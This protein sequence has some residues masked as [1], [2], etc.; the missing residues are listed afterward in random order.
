VLVGGKNLAM[1]CKAVL[2]YKILQYGQK[3]WAG[4]ELRLSRVPQDAPEMVCWGFVRVE[5]FWQVPKVFLIVKQRSVQY[6]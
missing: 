2:Q 3:G 4:F 6:P 5:R 1:S